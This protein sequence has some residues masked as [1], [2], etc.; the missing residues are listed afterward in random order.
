MECGGNIQTSN[1]DCR[2][3]VAAPVWVPGDKYIQCLLLLGI[4]DRLF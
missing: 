3:S 1:S 4:K 2:A